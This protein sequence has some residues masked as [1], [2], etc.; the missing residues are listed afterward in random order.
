[1]NKTAKLIS[2]I[3][4][5][6]MALSVLPFAAFAAEDDADRVA[7][8]KANYSLLLEEVFDNTNFTSWS[9]VDQ[10]KKAIDNTMAVYTAFALYDGAW[11]NYASKSIE[12][13]DA[14]KILLAL[15]EKADYDFDDGYVDEIVKVLETAQDVNDFIQKV[16]EYTKIDV[17]ES[18]GWSTTFE[19][20]GDVVKIANAYQTYRDKFI[21]AY[22]RVLSVQMANA[23]YIDMLSY[24]VENTEY[25]IL[26][27]AAQK[28]IDDINASVED[29]L[30]QIAAQAAE[31]GANVGLE[32][33]AKLAL[34]SN[35]YTAVALKVYQTATSVADVL[36]N[37]GDQYPLIDTVKTAYYFQSDIADWAKA[38]LAGD[39]AEKAAIAVSF[40]LTA[41]EISEDALYNLKLAENQGAINKIKNKLYGTVYNDIE[42]NKAAL[43]TMRTML[44]DVAPAD[45]KEVKRVLTIY[46]PVNVELLNGSNVA[47]TFA[48]GKEDLDSNAFGVFTSV[49]SEYAKTYHK[50]AFLYD[51]YRVRLVGTDDGYVTL[52]MDALKDG[53]IE[54]WSFTD[55]KVAKDT[56]IVFDTDYSGT[57]Y[58]VASDV[59]GNVAFN[60]DFV[61]SEQKEVTAKEVVT[62]VTE[63]G[64][65]EAKSFLDKIMDF[66]RNLF[67]KIL[68]I[69]KK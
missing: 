42:V 31:D 25:D 21:E 18:A 27:Q 62:A 68:S 66:F 49:Y 10:N 19:V 26:R 45:M 47:Y 60:D 4:A 50:V 39:D 40:A 1:M 34:N 55:R 33:L 14:E 52:I 22:A 8:W 20:I 51:N 11:I 32:Y 69:F 65:E 5:V 3:L 29:A 58:Y 23:Y 41:R 15:I 24:I 30:M 12:K 38:A 44:F 56:K 7:S 57:P 28:L 54:D 17:F 63:V 67:D 36:W 64:K 6:V 46:C 61:P 43:D 2:V 53:A 59:N 9:Y 37:T 13:D 16:N 35:A 48:D